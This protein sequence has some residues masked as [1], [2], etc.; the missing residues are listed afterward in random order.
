MLEFPLTT[1][2]VGDWT[3][4]GFD[5]SEAHYELITYRVLYYTT[6]SSLSRC[7]Y[8][9]M[10]QAPDPFTRTSTR[11]T[12]DRWTHTDGGSDLEASVRHLEAVQNWRPNRLGP[13][14]EPTA[15]EEKR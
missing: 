15:H 9:T 14:F 7:Y 5:G 2:L 6:P 4:P 1:P 13:N 3:E 11:W 8:E 10:V 12:V